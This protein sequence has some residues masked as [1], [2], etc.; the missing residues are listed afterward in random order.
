MLISHLFVSKFHFLSFFTAPLPWIGASFQEFV[1]LMS[2]PRKSCSHPHSLPVL[3]LL[4]LLSSGKFVWRGETST[5]YSFHVYMPFLTKVTG[6]KQTALFIS[7]KSHGGSMGFSHRGVW[8]HSKK[9]LI[10]NG[11]WN[12]FKFEVPVLKMRCWFEFWICY[13]FPKQN[14]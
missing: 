2:R 7:C 12:R 6:C 1:L 13:N 10:S 9:I 5:Y 3:L 8:F 11:W 14:G 4:L